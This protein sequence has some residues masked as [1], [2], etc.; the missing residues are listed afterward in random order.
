MD[1]VILKDLEVLACHGVNPEEKV[2]KQRFIFTAKLS[3]DFERAAEKDDLSETVSYAAV[4][5]EI[6][7]FCEDNCFDLIET[8]SS[9]LAERILKKCPLARRV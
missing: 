3:V 7:A 6:K 8:L 1:E 4:K 5:K 9:R 2:N